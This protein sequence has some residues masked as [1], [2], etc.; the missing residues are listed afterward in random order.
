MSNLMEHSMTMGKLTRTLAAGLVASML[1]AC[2]GGGGSPVPSSPAT[3]GKSAPVSMTFS[4]NP[5]Q[6]SALRG[7]KYVSRATAGVGITFEANETNGSINALP[8]TEAAMRT[9]TYATPVSSGYSNTN[10]TCTTQASPTSSYSCTML[11]AAPVGYDNI[12]ITTWDQAPTTAGYANGA[13]A[14]AN[15]ANDLS[16]NDFANQLIL[17]NQTNTFNYV[18]NGVVNSVYLSVQPNTLVDGAGLGQTATEIV[19]LTAGT[20]VG[21]TSFAVSTSG[22]IAP[23]DSVVVGSG[24]G[25]AE[26]LTVAT[27]GANSFTTTA[28]AAKTHNNGDNVAVSG[29]LNPATLTL[30]VLAKDADGNVIIGSEPYVDANGTTLTINVTA[31]APTLPGSVIGT[32]GSVSIAGASAFTS[33]SVQTTAL[34]YN[35]GDMLSEQFTGS[36]TSALTIPV[37]PATLN[38]TRSAGGPIYIAASNLKINEFSTG[39]TGPDWITAGPDGNLWVADHAAGTVDAVHTGKTGTAGTIAGSV[40][41]AGA[42]VVCPDSVGS[43]E[44]FY[45]SIAVGT[46]PVTRVTTAFGISTLGIIPAAANPTFIA[47]CVLGPDGNEYFV[48][49]AN[50]RAGQITPLGVVNMTATPTAGSGPVGIAVGADG[51]IWYVERN[52]AKIVR[53]STTGWPTPT[54]KEYGVPAGDDPD[55]IS[56]GPDGNLYYTNTPPGATPRIGEVS[57]SSPDLGGTIS[58]T[59]LPGAMA[60]GQDIILGPDANLYYAGTGPTIARVN[61]FGSPATYTPYTVGLSGSAVGIAAG[62]DG[63]IWFAEPG[64]GKVGE[65]VLP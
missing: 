57:G 5:G 25:N 12:Q 13:Q 43:L 59:D 65:L 17:L 38:F 35:A 1:A 60:T 10:T 8:N 20:I 62:A 42:Y 52:V 44:V 41:L 47:A 53:V 36:T 31:G 30:N 15:T 55:F 33:P 63:N 45:D 29:V 27:V 7:R 28:G 4:F 14:F 54:Q 22:G 48:D 34:S 40:S 23:G 39:F 9:P 19:T 51:N 46:A 64:T 50:A 18:L 32:S 6:S 56:P 61:V 2:G 37:Y 16:T 49:N 58:V 24:T 26:T 3:G 11:I 21:A